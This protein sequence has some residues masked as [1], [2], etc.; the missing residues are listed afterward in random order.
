MASCT[1]AMLSV[2]GF[3]LVIFNLDDANVIHGALYKAASIHFDF[4]DVGTEYYI[5]NHSK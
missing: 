3:N 1:R 5:D 2:D 4:H